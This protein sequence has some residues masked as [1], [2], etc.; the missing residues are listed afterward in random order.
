MSEQRNQDLST[1]Q[2]ETDE[3]FM[4]R[5]T[6]PRLWTIF[7]FDFVF[8]LFTD[9]RIDEV[10]DMFKNNYIYEESLCVNNKLSS[11]QDSINQFIYLIRHW[12]ADTLS[13]IV[14]EKSS[15]KCIGIIVCRFC[16]IED[17]SLE[18]SRLRLYEGEKWN[19]IQNFKN[20]LS[21]KVDIYKHY[22]TAAFLRVYAWFILPEFRGQGLGKKLLDCVI[23]KQLP[24]MLHFGCNVISGIFTNKKSQE[25]AK[26]LGMNM[27]YEA[28]YV[29]W[30][31]QNNV[32]L[33]ENM[34]DENTTATVM[35]FRVNQK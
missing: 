16:S 28:N 4:T 33:P 19:I 6:Q 25:I 20:H 35:A 27:L 8:Q 31:N 21:Q 12:I 7:K 13:S 23:N 24:E 18:F 34:L 3:D 32:T 1:V 2:D 11:D 26:S 10:L 17:N 22:E 9:E 29:D 15:G 14:I 30:A 5:I